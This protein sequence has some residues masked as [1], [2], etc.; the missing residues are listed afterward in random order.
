MTFVMNRLLPLAICTVAGGLLPSA[1][2]AQTHSSM[3]MRPPRVVKLAVT[4]RYIGGAISPLQMEVEGAPGAYVPL[5]VEFRNV[6]TG[7]S[8]T[9]RPVAEAMGSAVMGPHPLYF[10]TLQ[11][12]IYDITVG[13]TAMRNNVVVL[14]TSQAM[15]LFKGLKIPT[16]R[17]TGGRGTGCQV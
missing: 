7:V 2:A 13:W 17:L 14:D 11:P 5:I 6:Q 9:M 16:I 10:P 4:C 1:A 3:V 8:H 12:G 15:F